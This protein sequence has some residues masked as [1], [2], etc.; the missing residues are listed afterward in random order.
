MK[1]PRE[2]LL[3]KHNGASAKLDAIRRAIV[4]Q[5]LPATSE[6]SPQKSAGNF[7]TLLWQAIVLPAPR[8]WS[9]FAAIW[10]AIAILNFITSSSN[11]PHV[12]MA[13]Q[14]GENAVATLIENQRFLAELIRTP[15]QPAAEPPRRR[16]T[17]QSSIQYTTKTIV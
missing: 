12:R 9:S 1:T 5:A 17:P 6:E 16:S 8:I 2:L 14:P 15:E 4:D 7:L 13:S 3:Q 10:L 11:A